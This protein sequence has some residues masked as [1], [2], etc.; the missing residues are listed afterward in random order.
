MSCQDKIRILLN[1]AD[2]IDSQQLMRVYGVR[3]LDSP[4]LRHHYTHVLVLSPLV[5][6]PDALSSTA[7]C[8]RSCGR[9]GRW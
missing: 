7:W 8:R 9:W 4:H 1:K 5:R 3:W 6:P 2:T